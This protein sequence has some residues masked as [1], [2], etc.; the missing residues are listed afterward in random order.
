MMPSDLDE[1]QK[2]LDDYM[3]N[4][5]D[6]QTEFYWYKTKGNGRDNYEKFIDCK[7]GGD[8]LDD[9]ETYPSYVYRVPK[10]PLVIF[11]LN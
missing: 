11:G 1:F 8:F 9:I 2:V 10:K 6:S 5:K 7:N 4:M 3:E